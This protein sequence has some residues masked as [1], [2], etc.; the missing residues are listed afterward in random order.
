M[1][2]PKDIGMAARIFTVAGESWTM[3]RKG[4]DCTN[5]AMFAGDRALAGDIVKWMYGS[6]LELKAGNILITEC[7]HAFRSAKFEGPYFAGCAGGK[8]PVPVVHSV[9]LFA[10][11][12][13]D[14]RITIDP[15]RMITEPVTYQDPCNISRN[16]GLWREAREIIS[17][18]CKDFR[19]M[20]P[21]EDHNHCC[22]G[23]G[24]YMPMGQ[25]YKEKRM[26][27][28]K[29]KAGQ[30]RATGAKI[31]IAPCHNCFDQIRDLNAAYTLEI[32]LT[33]FKEI[34]YDA[35]IIPDAFKIATGT[36]E[37]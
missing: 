22:G 33:T 36:R 2:N 17:R 31:V 37:A 4:W 18:T 32:R 13:R 15:E 8:P 19:D 28:G 14:G 23:G 24:G 9:A 1:Y 34:L 10:E 12:L 25:E 35:M 27:S 11:Y 6:A 16:G 3:P 30:I 5:L 26:Q 21:S 20:S 29:V 7:G